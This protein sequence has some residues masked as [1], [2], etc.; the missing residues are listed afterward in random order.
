MIDLT[1]SKLAVKTKGGRNWAYCYAN[2]NGIIS[3]SWVTGVYS[4]KTSISD[5][6][7]SKQVYNEAGDPIAT[8][9]DSRK[10]QVAI[11]SMQDDVNTENF[12]LQDNRNNYFAI[13]IDG[14]QES[15]TTNIVRYF[16][17]C[18][19]EQSLK[20]DSPGRSPVITFSPLTATGSV[21]PTSL[22]S[23]I[24]VQS[25]TGSFTV[26]ANTPMVAVSVTGS[27]IV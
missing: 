18:T 11:T 14:G 13:M 16:P 27:A 25:L 8:E 6:Q 2:E 26:P 3:G 19:K 17:V 5:E 4:E 10:T 9:Y 24:S 7:P 20:I 23:W 1:K 12:L 22:P 21:T 15:G